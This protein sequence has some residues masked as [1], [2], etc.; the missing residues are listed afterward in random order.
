MN[1]EALGAIA[2]LLAAVGVILSLIYLAVQIRQ[3][4]STIDFNTKALR[5]STYASQFQLNNDFQDLLFRN[6]RIGNIWIKGM[7]RPG[8]LNE[9][10]SRY[11]LNLASRFLRI[12]ESLFLMRELDL[13]DDKLFQSSNSVN[14]IIFARPGLQGY[15]G[16]YRSQFAPSFQAFLD[17][18]PPATDSAEPSSQAAVEG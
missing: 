15:W 3:T 7:H 1:W 17:S 18:L 14:S 11:F 4:S 6:E 10:E 16:K 9:T 5:G 12:Y 13:I 2:E 8:D